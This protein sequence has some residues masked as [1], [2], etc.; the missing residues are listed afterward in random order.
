MLTNKWTGIR[1][2]L[3]TILATL[4]VGP[5][6]LAQTFKVLHSF[7]GSGDGKSPIEGQ[8][9]D[10]QGNLYG[11]TN[12]G[13]SGDGCL[14]NDGCGMVYQLKPNSDGT[15]TETVIHAFNGSDGA[16]PLSSLLLDAHGNLY[17]SAWGEGHYPDV[18]YQLTPSSNGA[19]TESVL[20]QFPESPNGSEPGE[21]TFDTTGNLYGTTEGGS[22]SYSGIAFSLNRSS[23]W[24]ERLLHIFEQYPSPGGGDPYGAITFDADG[25]LYGTTAE[26]AYNAGVVYYFFTDGL[27]GFD[28]DAPL[29]IDGAGNLYGT[30]G[31]GG[32]YYG[33]VAYEITP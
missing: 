16:Y 7:G 33:G 19:W 25:N 26:G 31:V 8:V 6:A 23:E 2:L 14:G 30:A 4:L 32:L 17:G 10:G 3:L 12:L 22:L 20:Y 9:F 21:L 29:T 27:D 1:T 28:P 15:W 11:I 18:I 13:P 5:G 24:Q